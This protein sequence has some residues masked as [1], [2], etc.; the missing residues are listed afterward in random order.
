MAPTATKAWRGQPLRAGRAYVQWFQWT[1]ILSCRE[2]CRHVAGRRVAHT[3]LLLPVHRGATETWLR[4]TG[5]EYTS[6]ATCPSQQ[7]LRGRVLSTI[8]QDPG[9]NVSEYWIR[10]PVRLSCK[11]EPWLRASTGGHSAAARHL[12]LFSLVTTLCSAPSQYPI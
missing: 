10:L 11:A 4:S 9:T 3:V 7:S 8:S 6:A 5:L 2:L 12:W 1:T